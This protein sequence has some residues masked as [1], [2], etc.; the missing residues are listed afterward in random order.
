MHFALPPRTPARP[1][2][3]TA[4]RSS[5]TPLIRRARLK[6][7]GGIASAI[8]SLLLLL[9]WLR[10]D[11]RAEIIPPGTPS[12]VLVTVFAS[13]ERGDYDHIIEDNRRDYAG[14]HGYAAFFPNTTDYDLSEPPVPSSWAKIPAMRHAMTLYPYSTYY[15]YLDRNGLIMQPELSVEEHIMN[16]G[17]L[18][19]IMLLDKPVVPPESVIH[20]YKNIKPELVDA[21]FTQGRSDVRQESFILR[22]GEWAKFFLDAWF[23]SLYRSYNFQRA[24]GH[25]LEHLI[26]WHGTILLRLALVPQRIMNAYLKGEGDGAYSTGDFV[27][28]LYGCDNVDKG[29]SCEAE[30]TQLLEH[31][32][33]SDTG[34]PSEKGI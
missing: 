3:Y 10:G 20:T 26:Q 17:R 34:K 18:R 23:D 24:E 8:I 6:Q 16:P 12:V 7:L 29:R 2:S 25:A 27:A 15:F 22:R 1:P 33:S 30:A 11:K 4:T 9:S 14:R 21:V 19:T 28:S 13:N 31:T 32:G 5:R